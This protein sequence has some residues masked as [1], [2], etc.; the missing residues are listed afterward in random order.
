LGR[1]PTKGLIWSLYDRYSEFYEGQWNHIIVAWDE[2][3]VHWRNFGDFASD[4]GAIDYPG[5]PRETWEIES[6]I[7]SDTMWYSTGAM[8]YYGGAAVLRGDLVYY[9]VARHPDEGDWGYD[10]SGTPYGSAA[11]LHSLSLVTGERQEVLALPYAFLDGSGNPV[12]HDDPS[13]YDEVRDSIYGITG[14]FEPVAGYGRMLVN[15]GD[16]DG[17]QWKFFAPKPGENDGV[18]V[19]FINVGDDDHRDW[20][21]VRDISALQL[22]TGDDDNR[23]W[24]IANQ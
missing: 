1:H 13:W 15:V 19:G 21:K 18:G 14:L 16:D 22:N 17:R 2:D 6:P 23:D 11:R 9:F 3:G 5:M 24:V 4:V 8:N 12:G 10:G 7:G 20:R